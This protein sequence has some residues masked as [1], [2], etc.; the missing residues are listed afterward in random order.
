VVNRPVRFDIK[1]GDQGVIVT[2]NDPTTDYATTDANGDAFATFF[3]PTNPAF[4]GDLS[5]PQL[6]VGAGDEVGDP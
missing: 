5:H 3:A 2:Q 4:E 1:A 6:I